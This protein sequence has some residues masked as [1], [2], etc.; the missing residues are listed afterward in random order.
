M[1][2]DLYILHIVAAETQ[3]VRVKKV[4][5]EIYFK[6]LG[7]SSIGYLQVDNEVY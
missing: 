1:K 5:G 3:F 4:M 6:M 7:T 2:M